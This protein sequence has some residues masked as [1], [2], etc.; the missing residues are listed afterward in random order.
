MSTS[1][2]PLQF[3]HGSL[4]ENL[5]AFAEHLRQTT[6]RFNLGPGEVQDALE[7]LGAINLGSLQEVRQALKLIF[8][9]NLEQ[10]RVFDDLFF[11]F[12]LPNRKRMPQP[13]P[14]KAVSGGQGESGEKSQAGQNPSETSQSLSSPHQSKIR[15]APDPDAD[16][17]AA[18]LLK[19]MFSRIA[20]NEAQEVEIP[21]QDLN[22]MLQAATALVNQ[23]RLGRS[24]RWDTAPKGARLHLRRTLRKALHTGGEPLYPAWL[25]HPKRQPRFVFV[26]DGSRSMQVYADRLLQFAFALRMRCN[27]VEVFAF[28]TELKR[29]TRQLEK[30]KHL[31]ERPRLDRLGQAWGGGTQIGE[32]LLRL[33]QSYGGLIRGDTVVIVASDGLDTGAPEVLEYAL[34]QIYHRS[35]ALIWLNPLQS[36]AGYDPQANCMRTALPYIDRLSAASTP[37]E[38]A[39]ITHRLRLRK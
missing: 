8:C 31:S 23:V 1:A 12:F 11:Q 30:A 28:S 17:W 4:P 7:A 27:R 24:R 38:Y 13:N 29:I 16:H 35:A 21:Q 26:L 25:H 33:E 37:E 18:P 39:Q 32:N 20:G 5:I 9:S 2:E 19:A 22:A 15:P 36:Q 6:L 34:R 3:P 14:R 10:E